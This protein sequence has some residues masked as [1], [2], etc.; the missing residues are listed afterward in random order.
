VID[1]GHGGRDPGAV[2]ALGTPEKAVVLA[3]ARELRRALRATGRYR[4]A[5]T[6]EGDAFVPLR[7]R[8]AFA[9]RSGAALVVSLHANSAPWARG[10]SVYTFRTPAPDP[11]AS[12]SDRHPHAAGPRWTRASAVAGQAGPAAPVA[13]VGRAA[14]AGSARLARLVLAEVGRVA[15]LLGAPRREA[16]FA[17]LRASGIPSVLV[18]LGF[19]SDP[20]EEALLRRAVHRRRLAGALARAVDCWFACPDQ[21]PPEADGV[22]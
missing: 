10:A 6:R 15:P 4:V 20:G 12:R 17:V 8:V 21:R 9:R 7:A 3:V 16:G 5:L 11:P 2:G 13:L 1:P 18:E 22:G 19:L 14:G